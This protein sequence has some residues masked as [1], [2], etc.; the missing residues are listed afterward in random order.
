MPDILFI[1]FETSYRLSPRM[2]PEDLPHVKGRFLLAR[3]DL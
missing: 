3:P 2:I 1:S